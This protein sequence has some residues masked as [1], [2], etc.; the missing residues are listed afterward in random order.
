MALTKAQAEE[1]IRN[2]GSVLYKGK[3]ITK[4][5]HLKYFEGTSEEKD[6]EK[7]A[8][9]A[10]LAELEGGDKPQTAGGDSV[11]DDSFEELNRHTRSELAEM[12]AAEGVEVGD[13]D[14]KAQIIEKILTKQAA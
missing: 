1:V 9:R 10:R 3:L 11:I 2:G 8:L 14:T 12:A 6:A 13:K 5:E 4:P 7:E